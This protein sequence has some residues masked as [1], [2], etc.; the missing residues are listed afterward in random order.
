MSL[1]PRRARLSA[2]AKINLGLKVLGR[3]ADGYHDLRTVFQTVSLADALEVEFTPARSTSISVRS[4]PEIPGNLVERAARLALDA[5]RVTGRAEF[6]LKKRIP[7]G[8]GLGGGSSD[9]AAVLLALPVLAGRRLPL[10]TLM[11]TASCLGSDVPFFLLGGTAIAL[12]RGTEVYPLA[13]RPAA[14]G[15]LVAPAVHVATAEAYQALGRGSGELT[16]AALQDMISGFQS[17]V[18]E[19]GQALPGTAAP[20]AG[21]NDFESVV[22]SRH[23]QLRSLKRRLEKLGANPA[24]LSG[25]GSALFGLFAGRGEAERARQSILKEQVFVISLV[26]RARYRALWWR[27]LSP[28]IAGKVW[29]PQSR[30]V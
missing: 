15:V 14:A 7:M 11:E 21:E 16:S 30:Y 3:R 8:A 24:M 6:R 20:A 29:P 12:G 1:T 27:R 4:E 23:P 13:D 19:L 26:S 10:A 2:L 28:H 5:M 25:S 17:C 18:W 9:A 22:F